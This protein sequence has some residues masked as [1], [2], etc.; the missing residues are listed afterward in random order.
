MSILLDSVI[1]V[2]RASSERTFDLCK[3]LCLAQGVESLSIVQEVPF[4]MALRKCYAIGIASNM[5]WMVTVDAD[6][7]IIDGAVQTLVNHAEM[8]PQNFV[9]LEGRIYDKITGLYRQAGHR[10]YRTRLLPLALNQIPHDGVQ[11][12]PEYFTLQQMGKLGY[13]SRRISDVVG[14]HD[15]E[16]S[17][18]DIYRK[19]F[20]HAIKHPHW[21]ADIIE[22][23]V[24]S[25]HND[26]DYLVILKGLW[27]GLT[28]EM[29]VS[30]DRRKFLDS[31]KKSLEYLGLVEKAPIIDMDTFIQGFT[32]YFNNVIDHNAPPKFV[33]CDEPNNTIPNPKLSEKTGW[34]VRAQHRMHQHGLFRGSVAT[35]GALFKRIGERLDN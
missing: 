32:E 17:Y 13:P 23:C 30:I 26:P 12:R 29:A 27:D 24:K 19:S 8:M 31:G 18:F 28:T 3:A 2:I 21:V 20:V 4:E 15:F 34:I 1:V 16:Q 35:I 10:I 9:Q 25:L 5:K 11:L 6:V 14:L 7:L 22:R 33:H